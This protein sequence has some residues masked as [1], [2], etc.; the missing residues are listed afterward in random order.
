M[1]AVDDGG[2]HEPKRLPGTGLSHPDEVRTAQGYGKALGL[3]RRGRLEA[4]TTQL[5]LDVIREPVVAKLKDA[6]F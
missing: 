2:Q 4:G 1:V 6:R 3:D 5:L